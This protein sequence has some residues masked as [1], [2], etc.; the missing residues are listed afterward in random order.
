MKCPRCQ[1]EVPDG[2]ECRACGVVVAKYRPRPQSPQPVGSVASATP[3]QPS[4]DFSW[5]GLSPRRRALF[6]GELARLLEAGV[7]PVL[8][9]SFIEKHAR[10]ALQK[11]ASAARHKVQ[12]GGQLW[13]ALRLSPRVFPPRVISLI[14]AAE[15]TGTVPTALQALAVAAELKYQLRLRLLRAALYPF[16]LF[17][18]S[19]FLLP[20]ASLVTEGPAA[21]LRKALLPYLFSLSGLWLALWL[22]PRL[23]ALL[24]G[25]EP[26]Q[27]AVRALP[28]V[29]RLLHAGDK[30]E[31]CR[32]LAVALK[33]GL[34]MVSS[35]RLAALA[36]GLSSFE[37]RVERVIEYLGR[38]GTLSEAFGKAGLSDAE[39]EEVLATGEASGKLPEALEQ[40]ARLSEQVYLHGVEVGVQ[41]AA[42]LLLLLVY[43]VVIIR[44]I[45]QYTQVLEGYQNQMN[46]LLKELGGGAGGLDG[47]LR[48]GGGE[49][50]PELR[51]ILK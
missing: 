14:A 25:R 9:F 10:G 12:Q 21:Y 30:A 45:G 38:G 11:A 33:A 43:A 7:S 5:R 19:F 13:E 20:L 23:I 15:R 48:G 51:E 39:L 1:Q 31:F 26:L 18:L 42:V 29:G 49:L 3:E 17:T 34:D 37:S 16:I 2:P 28:F 50:P 40:Q 27:R 22:L 4:A 35:L 6:Y 24:V 47:L 46:S 32:Q 8:A 44:V 41:L 36:T